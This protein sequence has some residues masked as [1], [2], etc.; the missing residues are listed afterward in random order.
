[1]SEEDCGLSDGVDGFLVDLEADGLE[2]A[3][4]EIEFV[5]IE[6][7]C[8]ERELVAVA[9]A[10]ASRFKAVWALVRGG[11]KGVNP[12]ETRAKAEVLV[13]WAR[14]ARSR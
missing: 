2:Q 9:E 6:E 10:I 7:G 5:G 1:V 13:V 11:L 14:A 4:S 8:L 3:A 12:G